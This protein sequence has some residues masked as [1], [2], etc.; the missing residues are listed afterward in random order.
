MVNWFLRMV[1]KVT[2]LLGKIHMPWVKKLLTGDEV[3][4]VLETAEPGDVI[5]VRTGGHLTSWLLDHIF[6]GFSHVAMTVDWDTITDS[7]EI[8][9]DTRDMLNVLQGIY[10]VVIL[11]P[12]I[13]PEEME[14]MTFAYQWIKKLDAANNIEYNYTLVL[15]EVRLDGAPSKLQCSQY[16]AW[17][18]NKG[19]EG[20][21]Q[22]RKRWG[23]DSYTPN[24]FY[25]MAKK[26][27]KFKI[28][29][30]F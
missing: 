20:F 18:L 26:T 23:F 10:R 24:D 1:G 5:L 13:L 8:G 14:K 28:I 12:N 19:R 27:E 30:E 2:R 22:P 6:G 21:I 16:V 7:T 4:E 17:L 15:N 25:A 3:R 9:V 29:K 11:R